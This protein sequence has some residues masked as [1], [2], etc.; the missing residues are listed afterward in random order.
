MMGV[1]MK[2]TK[3]LALIV[4]SILVLNVAVLSSADENVYNEDDIN[5]NI[6]SNNEDFASQ[7]IVA[8]VYV[9][10]PNFDVLNEKDEKIITLI[11]E[12]EI[13][14]QYRGTLIKLNSEDLSQIKKVIVNLGIGEVIIYHKDIEIAKE[15]IDSG[16]NIAIE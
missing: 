4:I 10:Y 6:P 1:G 13:P 3:I 14:N 2:K 12:A 9:Q 7:T 8:K 11:K 15:L 5:S 16:F